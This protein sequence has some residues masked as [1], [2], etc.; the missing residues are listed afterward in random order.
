[1]FVMIIIV[2][3]DKVEDKF[4]SICIEFLTE[5]EELIR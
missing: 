2:K 1:M 5:I 3:K 4:D